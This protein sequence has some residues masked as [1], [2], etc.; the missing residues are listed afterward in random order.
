MAGAI[1]VQKQS[2][3]TT[4]RQVRARCLSAVIGAAGI[5]TLHV[6]WRGA[7]CFV[8]VLYFSKRAERASVMNHKFIVKAVCRTVMNF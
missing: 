1:L 4:T 7:S 6:M 2:H 8:K 5:A 3:A